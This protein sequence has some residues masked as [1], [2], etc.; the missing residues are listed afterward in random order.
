MMMMLEGLLRATKGRKKV[1]TMEDGGGRTAVAVVNW[2]R[3]GSQVSIGTNQSSDRTEYDQRAGGNLTLLNA[4][5]GGVC[6]KRE[7]RRFEIGILLQTQYE[8]ASLLPI[9][10][11]A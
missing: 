4:V 2:N 3:S 10:N 5:S 9:E 11:I 8:A 1:R 6:E 7:W